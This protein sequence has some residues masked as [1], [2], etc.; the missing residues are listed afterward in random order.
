MLRLIAFG[1]VGLAF[2]A[3]LGAQGAAPSPA[4]T[5]PKVTGG[6][7]VDG[8]YAY[9]FNR[10]ASFDRAFTTQP[11]RHNEFN[12]NL[13][14][15]EA[16]LDGPRI[17]ARLA[18]QTGTS[19]Q[20]NYAAEPRNGSVSGPDLSRFVQEAVV[21]AKLAD[22]LW[23][24]GGVFLSHMG[25]E[26]WV[27]RDNPT[28]T[29]SLVADYSP[30]YQ[31]GVK[32]AWQATPAISAQLDLLNGWQ[33]ISETN[34]AKSV[35]MRIDYAPSANTVLSYYN[36]LGDEAPDS[37]P[38]RRLRVF[39]GVGLKSSL[40]SRLQLLAEFDYGTQERGA[41]LGAA[42]WYGGTLVG[43]VQITPL[44]TAAARVER[45]DDGDQV[46]VVTGLADGFRVNGASFGL[47]VTPAPR[48]LWRSEVRGF[49]GEHAVF[50]KRDS[51]TSNGDAF[52]VSS[53]ALTF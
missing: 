32:L 13:A 20:S 23:V 26:G 33:I 18:L 5:A 38:G 49:E 37:V 41:G 19:V 27:S 40:S 4:D 53:L 46:I 36:Y 9:D 6:A 30:Y 24:D 15:V 47:D 12:V 2:P 7:F 1:L 16:K 44:V 21:G 25:M 29:R 45:Y 14:F 31:S 39:N 8:Y 42:H 3:H 35:G 51:A 50:P 43:R 17:R 48:L 52:V 34:S 28:Y 22:N 11:A 10:P